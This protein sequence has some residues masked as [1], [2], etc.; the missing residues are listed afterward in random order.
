MPGGG[1]GEGVREPGST[2]EGRPA[3]ADLGEFDEELPDLSGLLRTG[4]LQEPVHLLVGDAG[5]QCL[6]GS[7]R[8]EGATGLG[9]GDERQ[10][11]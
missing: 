10:A 9:A 3:G 7:G 8:E 5:E 1:D 4:Q 2:V 6:A 11:G